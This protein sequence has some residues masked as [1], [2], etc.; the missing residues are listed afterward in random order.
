[1]NRYSL[2]IVVPLP[3]TLS[4]HSVMLVCLVN[5]SLTPSLL[6]SRSLSHNPTPHT[7]ARTFDGSGRRVQEAL[8]ASSVCLPFAQIRTCP[9]PT[10]CVLRHTG[11]YGAEPSFAARTTT[12]LPPGVCRFFVQ[13]KCRQGEACKFIHAAELV[14]DVTATESPY[15]SPMGGSS[16]SSSGGGSVTATATGGAGAAV[17]NWTDWMY[18]LDSP[19]A[20][21]GT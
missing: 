1:M 16:S 7:H 4:F 15:P 5:H 2:S 3:F 13:G 14:T 21:D 10:A 12:A 18:L 19:L 9:D 6:H 8:D 20:W 17:V 11:S